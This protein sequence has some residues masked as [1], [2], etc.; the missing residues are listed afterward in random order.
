MR[1]FLLILAFAGMLH[2]LHAQTGGRTVYQFLTL[3]PSARVTALGGSLIAVRDADVNLAFVNPALLNPQMHQALSF[4][5]DFY[6]GGVQNGYAVYGHFIPKWD[7]TLHG[8]V[9]YMSY[10]VFDATDE[11]GNETG[12]FKAAEYAIT[13]GAGKQ[14]YERLSVGANLKFVT[15]RLESYHSAGLVGDLAATFF[16]TTRR[17]ALSLV[18]NNIGGQ[19]RGYRDNNPEKVPFDMQIGLAHRLRYLPFRLSITYHDLHR[20]NILYDDPNVEETGSILGEAPKESKFN[21]VVDNLFRHFIFS[22]EIIFGKKEPLRLRIGYNHQLR[23]ELSV[24]NF[25]SLTGFS[26]GVGVKINR[27]RIDYGRGIYH[28]AGGLN[29]F[30][31]STNLSEFSHKKMLD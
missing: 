17:V 4:S 14:L 25:R 24:V 5:H 31:L 12:D 19:L 20:W 6:L 2:S 22:G 13:L 28:I 23:K 3:S 9:Q 16:D 1:L 15:S 8:G 30:T 29:H 21:M 10:G 27:F 11:I 26:F 7:L 18:L